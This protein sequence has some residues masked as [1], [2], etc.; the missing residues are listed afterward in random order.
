M[1]TLTLLTDRVGPLLLQ[2]MGQRDRQR[3]GKGQ[4]VLA[5]DKGEDRGRAIAQD[6]VFDRVE[7]RHT[8]LPIIRVL[9]HFDKLVGSK[10][11]EFEWAGADRMLAHL[12][13]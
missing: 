3:A 2:V 11:D 12:R 5:G 6:R 10:L 1:F 7:V 8:R 4:L 13:W 9:R